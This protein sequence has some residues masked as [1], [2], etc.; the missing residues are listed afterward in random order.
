MALAMIGWLDSLYF[1]LVAVRWMRPNPRWLPQFCRLE[2]AACSTVVDTRW[3]RLFGIPNGFL[4]V[5]WYSALIWWSVQAIVKPQPPM[6]EAVLAA[7][8]FVLL[9][10]ILLAWALLVRLRVSCALCF[11]A[12]AVNGAVV[13]L[14]AVACLAS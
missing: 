10:S 3:G 1:A 9:L 11:A 2:G 12:H 5:A 6:C 13:A 7:S 4:G 8:T 14:V